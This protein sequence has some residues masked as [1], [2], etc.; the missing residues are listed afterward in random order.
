MPR[1]YVA[2]NEHMTNS[3]CVGNFQAGHKNNENWHMHHMHT[4]Y[5]SL[6]ISVEIPVTKYDVTLISGSYI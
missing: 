6:G 3:A 4:Y 1:L 5:I 2:V